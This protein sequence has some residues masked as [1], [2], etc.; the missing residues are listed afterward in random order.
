[1]KQVID[2]GEHG[3][4]FM[5]YPSLNLVAHTANLLGV[6]IGGAGS[7]CYHSKKNP[8]AIRAIGNAKINIDDF[9][10]STIALAMKDIEDPERAHSLLTA[11][12]VNSQFPDA[13]QRSWEGFYMGYWGTYEKTLIGETREML[14]H[15]NWGDNLSRM[16]EAVGHPMKCDF[17]VDCVE[18]TV[19]SC[20]SIKKDKYGRHPP[21]TIGNIGP[22]NDAGFHHEGLHILFDA[23]ERYH[24]VF[25]FMNSH[26]SPRNSAEF[27]Y[28]DSRGD[29]EQA[30][31]IALD[32]AI[33][34]RVDYLDNCYI[35]YLRAPV[36]DEVRN[37]Y[38]SGRKQPLP[39]FLMDLMQRREAE[40]FHHQ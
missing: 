14:A 21:V 30:V 18:A 35:G 17:Y 10:V 4:V 34:G 29:V 8:Y 28:K 40:I 22:R 5:L 36:Y 1:M 2:R 25:R 13:L 32:C 38:D 24:P 33:R 37:W 19:R 6:S 31:V 39:E 27:P 7:R 15:C 23:D 20:C 3:I 16:E 12:L 26:P 11:F 9:N